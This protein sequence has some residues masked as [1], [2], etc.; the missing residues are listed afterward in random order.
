MTVLVTGVAGF[1]GFHT[2][3]LL[4][5]KNIKVIGIDCINNYYDI[6]L[7]KER[8]KNLISQNKK[9]FKFYKVDIKNKKT[10]NKIFKRYKCKY[11]VHL[12]AQAGVRFSLNNPDNYHNSNTTGFYN[13]LKLSNNY[14]VKH[15][16]FSSSSSVYGEQNKYPTYESSS[17]DKPESFYAS[18]KIAGEAYA[19]A[20]SKIYKLKITNLRFFTVYGPFGRPDMALFKLAECAY[21]KKV[22]YLNNRGNHKRD[23]TYIDDVVSVIKNVLTK[24]IFK[25]EKYQV[26]NICSSKPRKLLD[27]VK[28][29]EKYTEKKIKI[30]NTSKQ[31]GD[32]NITYGS[33]KKLKKDYM[34]KKFVPLEIGVRNFVYWF[35]NFYDF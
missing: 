30:K 13:I 5:K 33:N 17:T 28:L 20:F 23:F 9:K 15:L 6:K 1:I 7:K 3:S 19:H 32:V 18:T 22:F 8:L 26:Y 35:K 27:L 11:V 16:I 34:K 25:K 24:P 31:K 4:L 2:A 29:V 10:L 14:R 21:N 12:A